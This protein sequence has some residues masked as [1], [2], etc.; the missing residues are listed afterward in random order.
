MI[1][2]SGACTARPSLPGYGMWNSTWRIASS[3]ARFLPSDFTTV[4]GASA[5]SLEKNIASFAP[6]W[7]SRASRLA[8]SIGESLQCFSGSVSRGLKR[9]CCSS[10]VALNQNLNS[11]MP[12]R[13]SMRPSS[14]ASRMNS[15]YSAGL[16]APIT[17]STPA[18]SCQERSKN[19]NSPQHGRCSTQRSYQRP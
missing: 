16:Q 6:V 14:G 12:V 13:V 11:L 4:Q 19:T 9:R 15:R 10:R 7:S 1:S 2:G 18:R 5:V 8:L 17:R 3:R